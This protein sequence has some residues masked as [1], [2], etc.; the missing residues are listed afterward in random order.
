MAFRHWIISLLACFVFTTALAQIPPR[1]S[2][3][4]LVNNLSKQQPNFLSKQQEQS[5]E[6]T[7]SDF[8]NETSN[9]ICIVIVDDLNGMDQAS[10]ATKILNDWGIGNS[11]NNNGVVILVKPTGSE[12]ERRLF[13]S[14]GYGLEGAITDIQTKH[15]RENAIVPHFQ[16]GEYY[17]GLLYGVQSLM[18]AAKGEYNIGKKHR[19]PE[20][21]WVQEHPIIFLIL[22]VIAVLLMFRSGGG[23]GRR[24][25]MTYFGGGFGGFGRGFGGGGGGGFS[26]G[27]GFGGFGGGR[28]GGGGSGGSW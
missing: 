26:G 12:G 9:Q 22:V 23:G 24:G 10:F 17:E 8:S 16:K 20:G 6:R 25:G 15:I 19:R 21:N 4:R 1:P 14:V 27:G 3:A 13:I 7:L 5:L 28:G 11:K 18:Q 2:P